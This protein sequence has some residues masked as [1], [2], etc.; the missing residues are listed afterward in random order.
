MFY[1]YSGFE[2]FDQLW[3]GLY[4]RKYFNETD[5]SS[6]CECDGFDEPGDC[7]DCRDRFVWID[8]TPISDFE[9]WHNSEPDFGERCVRLANENNLLIWRGI[10]C[11][12]PLDYVC[13]RGKIIK[14]IFLIL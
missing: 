3:I 5:E 14:E 11:S 13:S 10:L 6:N 9:L 1:I 4:D 8:E 2:V 7:K 12:E